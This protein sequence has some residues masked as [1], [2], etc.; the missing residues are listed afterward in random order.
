MDYNFT[1]ESTTRDF[2]TW[3][4]FSWLLSSLVSELLSSLLNKHWKKK[5]NSCFELVAVS[6]KSWMDVQTSS[7]DVLTK[8]F[9]IFFLSEFCLS[10]HYSLDVV[11]L[12][13]Q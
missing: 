8:F 5:T 1:L 3:F 9:L 2:D 4:V 13:Y 10:P 6:F 7:A 12:K 11:V